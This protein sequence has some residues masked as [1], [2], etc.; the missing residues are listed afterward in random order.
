MKT[1]RTHLSSI[2]TGICSTLLA[3]LGY[4]C[5]SPNEPDYPLM[6]GMPTGSF[7]IK[8]AVTDEKGSD[9]ENAEIRVIPPEYP[10][11][12]AHWTAKTDAE[13]KY[14]IHS[15]GLLRSVKVVCIPQQSSLEPDSIVVELD[16][17]DK[18][19]NDD[20]YI[21]HAEKTVDFIL[22]PKTDDK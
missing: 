10:S 14:F 5:S 13:G 7:E 3:L 15:S 16:Y 2:L 21:G 18:D 4:S 1:I 12:L 20:W 6:Y 22:K 19:N 11:Y 17:K 8:G 9:I